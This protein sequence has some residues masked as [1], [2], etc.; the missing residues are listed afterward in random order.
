MNNQFLLSKT[1]TYV[2]GFITSQLEG[3]GGGSYV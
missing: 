1:V 3:Q 2:P